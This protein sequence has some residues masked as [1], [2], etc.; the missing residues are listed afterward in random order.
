MYI[1][2]LGGCMRFLS[3]ISFTLVMILVKA[4]VNAS[5][6]HFLG[7]SDFRIIT[8][9]GVLLEKINNSEVSSN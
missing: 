7:P 8:T 9:Q 3:Y 4:S 5:E 1:K 2:G 6:A